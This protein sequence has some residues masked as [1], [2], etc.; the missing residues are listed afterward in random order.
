VADPEADDRMIV[1]D[2]KLRR[3]S[4]CVYFHRAAPPELKK[5]TPKS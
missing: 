5:P 3:S 1:N 4:G 2:E